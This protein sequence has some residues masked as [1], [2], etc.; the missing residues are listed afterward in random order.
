MKNLS[1]WGRII[2]GECKSFNKAMGG[3]HNAKGKT[4]WS[5]MEQ[6]ADLA[7]LWGRGCTVLDS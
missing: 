3:M 4:G 2:G 1:L 6:H 5:R 7:S